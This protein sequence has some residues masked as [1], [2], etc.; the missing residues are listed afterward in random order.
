MAAEPSASDVGRIVGEGV[1]RET[2]PA[3]K[4]RFEEVCDRFVGKAEV[5][6]AVAIGLADEQICP[7]HYALRFLRRSIL[8][9]SFSVCVR[10]IRKDRSIG[11]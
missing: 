6:E 3:G 11:F 1:I 4:I 7:L 2:N 10:I 8:S 9:T 5:G